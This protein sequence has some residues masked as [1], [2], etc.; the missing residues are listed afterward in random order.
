MEPSSG[1]PQP[2]GSFVLALHGHMPWVMH[3]GRWPHGEHWLFEAALGVYLPLLG[4]LDHLNRT[5]VVRALSLG[6]TPVLLEQLRNRTFVDGF[7]RWLEEQL[8]RARHDGQDPLLAHRAAFWEHRL[9]ESRDRWQA[10]GRDLVGA[11]AE[12]ARRGDVELLSSFA[13]HGYAPLLKHDRCIRAQLEAGLHTSERHLGFR[14][15][16]IW[17]PECAFRPSG[18]WTQPVLGGGTRDRMG[19]DR[20]LEEHGVTHFFVDAT[21]V[22]AARSEGRLYTNGQFEKVGWDAA[23]R[24]FRVGWRDVM[25]VHRVGTHGGPSQVSAFARHPAVSEQV[26]SADVG[27]P[28]DPH[29]LEFHK[30]KDG[31]GLRYWRVTDRAADLGAKEPYH[32]EVIPEVVA[33][34]ARHFAGVVRE[35]LVR[36]KNL[37]G[38]EGCVTATFDAELFGHWWFEGPAFLQEALTVLHRDPLVRVQC[39]EDRLR[40]HP[41]QE[42]VWLPEGSWGEGN[43]HRVWL[44]DQTRWM[45]EAAHRAEDRFLGLLWQVGHQK[46]RR[47]ERLLQLAARELLLLQASDWQFVIHTGGA[48]DYGFRRF[49]GHLSRFDELCVMVDDALAGR[50]LVDEAQKAS[51]QLVE[52]ADD[53]FVDVNLD[54]FRLPGD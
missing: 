47:A 45:W 42:V 35:R 37:S 49:A 13:T 5:G 30:K 10:A 24:E 15:R 50:R 44:N 25:E 52:T 41:P 16:G 27:Y 36:W 1:S 53:C 3:H 21:T 9:S 29:Y 7:D 6:L 43:D 48:V 4:V 54:W 31:D 38:R 33:A 40:T 2:S 23:D 18:P 46:R 12:R 14:P 22:G 34:H 8:Q 32:P 26:W 51:K 17:L 28:G 39:A 19:V 20:I 11:F